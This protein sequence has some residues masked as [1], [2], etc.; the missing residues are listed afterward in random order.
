M[1]SCT[2]F[3]IFIVG[4]KKEQVTIR[5]YMTILTYK[6]FKNTILSRNLVPRVLI[7]GIAV[8]KP[9]IVAEKPSMAQDIAKALGGFRFNKEGFWESSQ[10]LLT[11]AIGHLVELQEPEDYDK[12]YA[13]WRF[14]DLPIIPV[15]FKLKVIPK[16]RQQFAVIKKLLKDAPLVINAC[17]AGREGELIFRY[18]CRAAGYKGPVKRF[19]ASSLTPQAIKE[20]FKNLQD[21]SAYDNLA[22]AAECRSQ[23]D[24][25]IGINGTRAYTVK[26]GV[27]LS[28]GR[29]Q[30]PTLAMLVNREKEIREF[31]SEPFWQLIATFVSSKGEYEG[32]WFKDKEHRIWDEQTAK[33]IKDKVLGQN[34]VITVYEQKEKKESPPLLFDLTSLQREANQRYGY[35]AAKTLSIAQRLYETHKLITYPRTDSRYLTPDLI[36]TLPK[37]IEA[38]NWGQYA[39]LVAPLLKGFPAPTKRLVDASKVR[40]HH[41][42]IPTEV[43]AETIALSADEQKVYDLIV[44]RFIAAF[45]PF[46]LYRETK[47]VTEV[48]KETFKTQGKEILEP[49]WRL[50]ENSGNHKNDN[51]PPLQRGLTVKTKDVEIKQDETKPPAPYT[52]GTLLSAMEGAGK[53]I[54]DEE[55]RDAMKDAGLGTPATRAAIIERLKQVGY[56]EADGKHLRPTQKGEELIARINLPVLLSPELT[57]QWEKRLRDIE[58]GIESPLA[59]MTDV[60]ALTMALVEAARQSDAGKFRNLEYGALGKCPLCGGDVVENRNAYGCSNWRLENGGCKFTIWKKI[61]RKRITREQAR[62]LLTKGSTRLLRGFVSKNGKKF[63]AR[64]K[65]E[66]GEVVF[67][68]PALKG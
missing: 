46:C 61:A 36:S 39:P 68:F 34:G 4:N 59:F 63:S 1:D 64:L 6:P 16:Q 66:N 10:Y 52:E 43:S 12:S 55:L 18:I 17:D 26:H 60:T 42:I 35:S 30:T 9:V 5:L 33:A 51:L 19:W 21:G 11:Y 32:Q 53:L 13:E 31:K 38:V 22:A 25:L 44:R 65:L 8:G 28:V 14:E 49:G 57:G 47:I 50:V 15:E 37:R 56:I 2:F 24:W 23:G 45:Y 7:R 27:L 62:E 67:D 58:R 41:A 40:D 54:D 3:S 29:V 48:L 20:G